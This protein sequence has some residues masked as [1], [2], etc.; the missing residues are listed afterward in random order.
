MIMLTFSDI[1]PNY[2]GNFVIL[3]EMYES[4]PSVVHCSYTSVGPDHIDSFVILSKMYESRPDYIDNV[5]ILSE[6]VI[7]YMIR[8]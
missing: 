1:G 6:I 4:T 8:L 2:I 7:T 3:S 5:V